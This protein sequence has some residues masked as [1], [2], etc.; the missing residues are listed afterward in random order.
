MFKDKE[1]EG[2]VVGGGCERGHCTGLGKTSSVFDLT[3]CGMC[4]EF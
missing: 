4:E 3:R 2:G 1:V